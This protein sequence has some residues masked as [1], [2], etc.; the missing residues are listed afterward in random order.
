MDTAALLQLP[1]PSTNQHCAAVFPL[2]S[3]LTLRHYTCRQPALPSFLWIFFLEFFFFAASFLNG[4]PSGGFTAFAWTNP[5]TSPLTSGRHL[6]KR[7]K[8]RLGIKPEKQKAV[9]ELRFKKKEQNSSRFYFSVGGKEAVRGF[10]NWGGWRAGELIY[11]APS[12][13]RPPPLPHHPPLS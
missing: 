1:S 4:A 13:C 7:F 12:A 8:F 5:L 3:A 9:G 6:T 11:E 10:A 2:Q